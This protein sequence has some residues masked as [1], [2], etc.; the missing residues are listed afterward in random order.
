MALLTIEDGRDANSLA[1]SLSD[2][3]C[4]LGGTSLHGEAATR[5]SGDRNG[6]ISTA[7]ED[8]C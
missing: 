1:R 4:P 5:V 2:R 8:H 7:I 6:R 3:L